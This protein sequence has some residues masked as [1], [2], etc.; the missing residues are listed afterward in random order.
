M[1]CGPGNLTSCFSWPVFRSQGLER[2]R[3]E[4]GWGGTPRFCGTGGAAEPG[5]LSALLFWLPWPSAGTAWGGG[6]DP[7]RG[8]HCCSGP[9]Y[10]SHPA[11]HEKGQWPTSLLG[12]LTLK[13]R[14]GEGRGSRRGKART[15]EPRNLPSAIA[16]LPPGLPLLVTSPRELRPGGT[17]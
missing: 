16:S 9:H 17:E 11:G 12:P 1:V 14:D 10:P 6:G 2:V 13:P 4:M 15:Q 7:C 5:L 8:T 3:V